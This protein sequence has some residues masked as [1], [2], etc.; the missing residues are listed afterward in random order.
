MK[1]LI[2]FG[3]CAPILYA[4]GAT[5]GAG[6]YPPAPVV[7]SPGQIIT[8]FTTVGSVL[9]K[10][11]AGNPPLPASLAGFSATLEQGT[12]TI[13]AP[14]LSVFPFN[15]CLSA[16]QEPCPSIIG[17]TVQIPF[18]LRANIPGSLA[19]TLLTALSITGPSGDRIAGASILLQPQLDAVHVMHQEDTVLA[20]DQAQ[21]VGA[22]PAMVTHSNGKL[23]DASS[24]A[25]AGEELVMY[26]VGLGATTTPVKTGAASPSPAVPVSG[27]C[28]LR[29]DYTPNAP[30]S[31]GLIINTGDP[32]PLPAPL[33]VGLTPGFVGLYQVNFLVPAPPPGMNPCNVSSGLEF[34]SFAVVRSNL[35]VTLIGRVSFDGAAICISTAAS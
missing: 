11:E 18:E 13:P 1:Q 20:A 2:V 16:V 28:S 19:P 3:L 8:F 17:I 14:V 34:N 29:F 27:C 32:P 35:T 10:V 12:A 7:V 33:F 25:Q 23:V 24:P 6:Y 9:K 26:A 22:T 30:P 4:Q 5:V 21:P 15:P 31:P